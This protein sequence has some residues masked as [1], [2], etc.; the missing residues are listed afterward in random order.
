MERDEQRLLTVIREVLK[1][2]PELFTVEESH[3]VHNN[4][5]SMYRHMLQF[6]SVH[7]ALYGEDSDDESLYNMT[8][9]ISNDGHRL[10]CDYDMDIH[11]GFD[12]TVASAWF[13]NEYAM[14]PWLEGVIAQ[15]R[16][17]ITG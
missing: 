12:G 17:S 5:G 16:R 8:V 13:T 11:W 3:T 15:Y 2:E 1:D 6:R 9:W 7:D 10:S 14:A 4:D